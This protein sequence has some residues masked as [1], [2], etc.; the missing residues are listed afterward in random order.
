[1]KKNKFLLVALLLLLALPGRADEG[2][3]MVQSIDRALRLRMKKEG[4]KLSPKEIYSEEEVSIKDAIVSL[5]FGCT[6]SMV[7]PEGLLITN[8]HCAY[9]DVHRLST[10]EHNYLEDGFWALTRD[11]E[12]P[13]PGKKAYFLK[14]VLDV[15]DEVNALREELISAGKPF[16]MRKISYIIEKRYTEKGYG[17]ECSLSSMWAGSKYYLAVYE[18]YTDIR[19]VAAPPVSIAAFGGDEDNWEWPQQKCDFA[20]YRIYT[21]PD[22]TP[23]DYAPENIPFTPKKYLTLN[24]KGIK[25]GDF[26]MVLGYPGRTDRYSSSA[27]VRHLTEVTLPITNAFRGGQMEILRKEM[28]EDPAVRLLYSDYFFSLSNVQELQE[29]EVLCC[30]RYGVVGAKKAEEE[31]LGIGRGLLDTL[32]LQY[33]AIAEAERNRTW[34]R[35]TM[36]RG[37]KLSLVSL[38]LSSLSR[39]SGEG[40]QQVLQMLDRDYAGMDLK[41]EKKLLR[42][43]IQEYYEHID[44]SFLG[45]FQKE[46]RERFGKDYDAM[47]EYLWVDRRLVEDDLLCRFYSDVSIGDFNSV[48]DRI[49]R[50]APVSELGSRYTREMYRIRAENGKPQYPDANS[51]MRL[52]YGTVKGYQ[53]RD[54]IVALSR[55]THLGILEKNDPS[56]HD[57]S[58]KP[59]WE[60][61]LRSAPE[62]I[63]ANFLT[64]NDITGGNSGSPVL[65]GKGRL[66][67]L[68]FDGNKESLASNYYYTPETNRCVCVDIRFVLWT[69]RN[70]AGAEKLLSELTISE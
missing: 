45:P 11:K 27:K 12:V 8:H 70:Y 22:G 42:Y 34:Y 19:L 57:Y 30:R 5:D 62:P 53:P 9:G 21:A 47:T 32:S 14:R 40:R 16:G 52:S 58:L 10:P 28:D 66:I 55:S 60:E 6:G 56:R 36:V 54:G 50:D 13:V 26:A 7:S 41:V 46:L 38:R 33:E 2:M 15:T 4:L 17:P 59:S 31:R 68:C 35:E 1:M 49:Q 3:W 64:D 67:G 18:I 24:T 23:A 69:L 48:T 39:R 65:D 44:S 51:T 25:D 43:S 63:P 29:G 37:S 20:F 61:L